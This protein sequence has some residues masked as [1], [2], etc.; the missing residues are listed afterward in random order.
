MHER[1]ILKRLSIT[2][3]KEIS[4]LLHK[5]FPLVESKRILDLILQVD[6]IDYALN[7]L[8]IH[9]ESQATLDSLVY[10]WLRGRDEKE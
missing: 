3:L 10:D 9:R 5:Y 6:S 4:D 1:H 8:C 2:R 7:L